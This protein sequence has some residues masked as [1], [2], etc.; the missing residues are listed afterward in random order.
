MTI[1]RFYTATS[2]FL[3]LLFGYL[4]Y[5]VLQ[6]FLNAIAWAVVFSIVFYPVY[7]FLLRYLR[8][9]VVTST[10]T[11]LII[12]LIILGPFT[13]LSFVLASEIGDLVETINKDTIDSIRDV[14][15]NTKITRL[16][17]KLQSYTGMEGIDI[18]DIVSE[19][20]K[21][22]G[23]G[24]INSLSTGITNIAGMLIDLIFMLFAIFFFLKDGPD[25]LSRIRD[26]LPFSEED[27]NR[28]MSKVKDMVISTVYGGVV[29]A[30]IQGT[31]GGIAF[32]LLGIKSPVLWG[33]AMSVMSFLPM[34]GTFSI[35]GPM[36]GYLFIQG[37]YMKGI[38]LLLVGF[39]GISMVDNILKPIIISG[40]TKMPTL[41]V[42]FSVLGGIKLFGFIGFI[43]GPLVLA[44]FVSVFEIFRQKEGGENA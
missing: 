19:N 14:F 17:D 34:L 10:V 32:Y 16:F 24:M 37:Y 3:M 39:L 9:K 27:K 36:T 40:R 41:A 1:N 35:W 23:K 21:K 5:Q 28:I 38:I 42:F 44:L 2:I 15:T 12:I 30:I 31:L 20:I 43:M 33:T 26:Y 8:F 6:P 7:A 22:I 4:T 13:Y 18:S 29:V 25:F 11:L